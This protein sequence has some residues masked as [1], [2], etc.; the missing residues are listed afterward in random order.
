MCDIIYASSKAQFGLPEVTLGTIPG[1]GGTQRLIREVGKSKAMEMILTGQFIDAELAFKLGL[2]SKVV[3]PE[4]LVD[5]AIALGEKIGAFSRPTS[6]VL[7]YRSRHGQGLRQQG[8]QLA[9]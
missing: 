7:P 9:S 1:A 4:K 5:E 8:L 3:E 6:T 2:T